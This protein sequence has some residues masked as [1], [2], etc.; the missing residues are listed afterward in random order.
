[1]DK[2]L[3]PEE[4]VTIMDYLH[5]NVSYADAYLVLSDPKVNTNPAICHVWLAKRLKEAMDVLRSK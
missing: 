1:E 5:F 4:L 3:K 2:N